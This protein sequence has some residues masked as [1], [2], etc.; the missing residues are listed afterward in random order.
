MG[1]TVV[2]VDDRNRRELDV[3]QVGYVLQESPGDGCGIASARQR[4]R[5]RRD[6]LEVA[7][8]AWI[9]VP[10]I[11]FRRSGRLFLV[12][13]SEQGFPGIHWALRMIGRGNAERQSRK[14][15]TACKDGPRGLFT[16]RA[17]GVSFTPLGDAIRGLVRTW[18]QMTAEST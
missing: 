7:I 16:N 2:L 8:A 13:A 1:A 5:E 10:R 3:E 4:D 12:A 9:R 15:Y 11:G 6:R 14:G 18:P 17:E